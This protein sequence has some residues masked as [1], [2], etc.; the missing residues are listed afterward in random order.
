MK[1]LILVAPMGVSAANGEL[2]I[3]KAVQPASE[4]SQALTND[5]RFECLAAGNDTTIPEIYKKGWKVASVFPQMIPGA[6]TGLQRTRWTL[7]IEKN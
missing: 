1:K 6:S 5:T 4:H 3:A 2:C 7:V